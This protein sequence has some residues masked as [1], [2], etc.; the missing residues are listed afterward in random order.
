MEELCEEFIQ[1]A[2]LCFWVLNSRY[3]NKLNPGLYAWRSGGFSLLV[4]PFLYWLDPTAWKRKKFNYLKCIMMGAIYY[5]HLL[6]LLDAVSLQEN[7]NM[8]FVK[9]KSSL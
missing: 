8:Y 7:I 3:R 9:I 5:C 6:V 2:F 1:R 4:T